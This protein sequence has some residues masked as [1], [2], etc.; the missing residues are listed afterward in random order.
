MDARF[1]FGPEVRMSPQAAWTEMAAAGALFASCPLDVFARESD[2]LFGLCGGEPVI[3]THG[4]GGSRANFLAFAAYIRMA[5]FPN[6]AFFQYRK[7]RTVAEAAEQLDA[8]VRE[9]APAGGVHLVGHS[10]GG[11]ISRRY[12]AA[13][14]PAS[15]RSLVTIASPY[16]LSQTSPNE[17]AIFGD[18]DVIVPPPAPESEHPGM[19]KR[20]VVLRHTGHLGALFHPETL[21]LAATELRA[22]RAA[23]SERA[24]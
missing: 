7:F 19:F 15:V 8:R 13:A 10:L 17:L 16:S 4:L 3:L 12:A 1:S 11:T 18:E 22:H 20:T 24:D 23:A 21:R 14:P 2:W 9:I 5:G 6:V